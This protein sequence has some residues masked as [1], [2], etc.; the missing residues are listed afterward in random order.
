MHND[1]IFY[2]KPSQLVYGVPLS[3]KQNVPDAVKDFIQKWGAPAAF[4]SNSAAKNKSSE[5]KDLEHHYNI[6]GH[7]YSKP[8]YQN[9]NW[10]ENKIRDIKNMVNNIMDIM[11]TPAR[12]WLICTM[13]VIALMQLISQPSL[14][15][16]SVIQ[17]VTGYVQ[18]TF[19]CLHYHWWQ[20][21]YYLNCIA[22]ILAK[23]V[24]N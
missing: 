8:G 14:G 9:Q 15:A 11:G 16:I 4:L 23:V 18:D 24:K 3:A 13:Y 20:Q 17:K 10:V 21:V 19:K 22:R 1:A 2:T 6:S 7:H 5:I 12:C